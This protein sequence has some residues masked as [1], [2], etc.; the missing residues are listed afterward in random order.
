MIKRLTIVSLMVLAIASCNKD[1]I[2]GFEHSLNPNLGGNNTI[3]DVSPL[4]YSHQNP[5]VSGDDELQ[6]FVGNSLFNKNWVSAPASTTARDGLG[7][8][9]NARSCA[10]CHFK[11]GRG[12]SPS[13]GELAT[14]YLVRLSIE[15]DLP[16][17][18]YGDQLQD[19]ANLGVLPEAQI[20]IQYEEIAGAYP[21]GASYSVRKPTVTFQDV[22]YSVIGNETHTSPRVAPQMIGLGLLENI[23]ESTLIN[24]EDAADADGDGISGRVNRVYDIEKQTLQIGRFGWKSNTPNIKQQCAGA[25]FG[26]MG[27]TSSFHP[28]EGCTTGDCAGQANGG[29]PEVEEKALNQVALYSS[30]LAVPQQ[31]DFD[32]ETVK[33]GYDLFVNTGCSSCHKTNIQLNDGQIISP[34]TDLLLHDMGEGLADNRNDNLAT[35]T[36]WRTAPLWGMGLIPTVNG[37]QEL[38]HDGRARNIEE[39]ILW[40]GG[41]AKKSVESFKSLDADK[42]QEMIKFLE[43]I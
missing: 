37:H 19:Q 42:R 12:R 2:S 24:W 18:E 8:L 6:F 15:G 3:I 11:D 14:G 35:G 32:N 10:S 7:P 16:H 26:D 9:F 41:E 27:L 39:A 29:S 17:P 28:E 23:P 43:S 1:A 31:R 13:A 21:D 4:A 20:F 38:L 33:R 40:H 25:F 5:T 34:L 36:E 22:K 30:N